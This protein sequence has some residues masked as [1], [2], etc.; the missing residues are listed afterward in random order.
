M[1]GCWIKVPLHEP[2]REGST[3]LSL[4]HFCRPASTLL[5]LEAVNTNRDQAS[6]HKNRFYNRR[7]HVV[8]TDMFSARS[9]REKVGATHL[10]VCNLL[11]IA[12]AL[13]VATRVSIP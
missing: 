13:A 3:P 11:R 8:T 7:L 12:T 4:A 9:Q 6:R 2:S 10:K 1:I 5:A